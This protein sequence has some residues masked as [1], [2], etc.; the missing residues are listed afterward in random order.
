M[1]IFVVSASFEG[2]GTVSSIRYTEENALKLAL[3][4]RQQG[5][6]NVRIAMD[7]ATYTLEEFRWLIE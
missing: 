6:T 3:E 4:Y 1:M 2:S 7:D 5:H